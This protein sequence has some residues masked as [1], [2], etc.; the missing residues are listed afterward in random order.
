ML[1][2]LD[3]EQNHAFQD[4]YLELDY[5][6]SKVMFI[7]TANTLHTVPRPLLDRMEIIM[8]ST[9]NRELDDMKKHMGF[10]SMLGSN[11]VIVGI[12]GTVLGG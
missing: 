4:H 2:V 6:L 10:L 11:G 5:D 1:E 8:K 12:L 9:L 3:P 7:A